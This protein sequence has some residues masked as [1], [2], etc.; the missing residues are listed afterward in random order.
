MGIIIDGLSISLGCLFGGLLSKRIKFKSGSALAIG[1]MI[2]SLVGF[3][4]NLLSISEDGNIV[5]EHT[6]TVVIALVLGCVIGDKLRIEER[7]SSLS[8][9]KAPALNGFVDATLFFGIGG[10]QISGPILLALTN[11][12]FQLILKAVID[13]PFALMMGA[14][15]GKRTAFS[16][17][18]VALIQAAIALLAGSAGDFVSD[19]LL[20]QLCS[21]GYVILF[22]TGYNMISGARNKVENINMLPSI[23]L[24]IIYNIGRNVLNL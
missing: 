16:A 24:I 14:A 1:V 5:G 22:F 6:V 2:I 19:D 21:I 23:M 9:G 4:E 7:I 12:S 11:D 8:G 10:L 3:L 20:R 17:I 13:L 18:P 15:Y